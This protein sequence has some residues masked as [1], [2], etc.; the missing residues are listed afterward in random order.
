LTSAANAR[1]AF[2]RAAIPTD[3]RSLVYRLVRPALAHRRR[4]IARLSRSLRCS[5]R[6][7]ATPS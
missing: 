2:F 6:P 1:A 3:R 5:S 7:G 4:W